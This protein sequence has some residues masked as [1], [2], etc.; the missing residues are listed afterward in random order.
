MTPELMAT[1]SPVEEEEELAA[2]LYDCETYP[3]V[4]NLP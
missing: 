1:L 2:Q 3:V 4:H